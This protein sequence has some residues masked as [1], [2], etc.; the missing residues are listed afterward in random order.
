MQDIKEFDLK[1]LE[2]KFVLLGAEP[3]HA[4]QV[5]S[6]MYRRGVL[7]FNFMSDI[8]GGL[9]KKLA[10]NFYPIGLK[11]LKSLESKDGTKKI[12]LGTKD[13][14]CIEAVVI[15]SGDRSTGCVSS[16]IGC[17]YGCSFCASGLFGFKR[18]LTIGEIIEEAIFLKD[19]AKENRLTHLVF[20]GTGE[21]MDNY[22][23]VFKAV[24]ILNS[25]E[26]LNI[27]ARRITISTSGIIP[28]IE[29][30]SSEGL[31]VEL[32]VSLHAAN[33]RLRSSLMPINKKYPLK[34]LIRS[35]REYSLKT[36]RQVTF[37]YI[38]IKEVNASLKD[39]RDLANLLSNFKL[40]KVNLIPANHIKEFKFRPAPEID[41]QSFKEY[42][43]K[44]RINVTLRKSR[45]EDIGAAC[46]QLRLN[47]VKN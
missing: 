45:G 16:Q 44:S 21:P 26:G 29:R 24:R 41:V 30:L 39:A 15:P 12:L 9:R 10:E 36:R 33:E 8:P 32:S 20:M 2:Q 42:L 19:I 40:S 14:N 5:F 47:Y 25:K 22:N 38:L 13:N 46:G 37:E 18:N 28:G 27:G 4:R 7:D 34:E 31:Q 3:Y 23:N 35:C 1:D 43:I 17:K 11:M 6:W